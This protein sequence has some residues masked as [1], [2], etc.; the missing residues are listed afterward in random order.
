[1]PIP[2]AE[3]R[4]LVVQNG[5]MDVV[6][7]SRYANKWPLR[8][9]QLPDGVVFKLDWSMDPTDGEWFQETSPESSSLSV[10]QIK[11]GPPPAELS[12]ETPGE[13]EETEVKR[14]SDEGEA[15]LGGI[16]PRTEEVGEEEAS[17]TGSEDAWAQH[18]PSVAVR[19][20]RGFA[21]RRR[22]DRSKEHTGG[23]K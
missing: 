17:E 20:G 11:V 16:L 18:T 12:T 19:V 8:V 4:G 3:H 1:M 2:V 6:L 13:E 22:R 9:M 5:E 15:V 23:Q 14:G 10:Y 21:Q 7:L